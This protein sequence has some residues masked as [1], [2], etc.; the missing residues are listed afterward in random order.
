[1]LFAET[2]L[3]TLQAPENRENIVSDIAS[4]HVKLRE[5]V[6]VV[7]M[8][9]KVEND[10]QMSI[11][12]LRM[13]LMS[14]HESLKR[15]LDHVKKEPNVPL[16]L[17]GMIYE[18]MR[19]L[20]LGAL[21]TRKSSTKFKN[22]SVLTTPHESHHDASSP[23]PPKNSK[24][25]KWM[26]GNAFSPSPPSNSKLYRHHNTKWMRGNAFSA[27]PPSNSK[28]YRHCNTKKRNA[29]S[30]S[31]PSNSKSYRHHNTKKRRVVVFDDDD[32]DDD[33]YDDDDDDDDDDA[34]SSLVMMMGMLMVPALQSSFNRL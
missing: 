11:A 13:N 20:A 6:D 16:D 25:T 5:F 8:M 3:S 27:S 9:E 10:Q 4:F 21:S 1:M 15:G 32:G 17:S 24:F 7:E 33:D 12:K 2:I 30:A 26:R 19:E 28:S 14:V 18:N 29:F 22:L 34:M 23:S 31:P